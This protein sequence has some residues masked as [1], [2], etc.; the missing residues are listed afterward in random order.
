MKPKD[1]FAHHPRDWRDNHYVYP[2]ISRRSRGLSIGVNLNPDRAC[3]FDCIYCQ[4]DRTLPVT[5]R[6][7]DLN[8]LQIELDD[9]LQRATDGTIFDHAGFGSV[10]AELRRVNDVAFSGDGE[11]TTCPEFVGAVEAV[12]RGLQSFQLPNVKIVLITDACYLRRENVKRGLALMDTSNGEI[13]AK[14]DAG[15]DAYYKRVNRPNH[16]L[17]HVIENIVD[18]SKVR[19]IC[20]Q[21]LFMRIDGVG[22][23]ESEIDAFCNRLNHV[24]GEGGKIKEVQVYTVSR[25]PAEKNV[26]ALSD[27]EKIKIVELTMAKTGLNVVAY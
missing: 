10:P 16:S 3:N 4:V 2:V 18:A 12:V 23:D 15:T 24:V 25:D 5:V 14:L 1:V 13:W 19:P 22:P 7:V 20:I 26:T 6:D 9:M 11:P 21:S 8:R 27:E 17:D